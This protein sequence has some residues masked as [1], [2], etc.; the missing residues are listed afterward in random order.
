MC[1]HRCAAPDIT[2][3]CLHIIDGEKTEMERTGIL[4]FQFCFRNDRTFCIEFNGRKKTREIKPGPRA[5]THRPECLPG[6]TA[7]DLRFETELLG[8]YKQLG[9]LEDIAVAIRNINCR[10]CK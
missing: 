7:A 4:C 10:P 2:G 9:T 5:V 6:N 3:L 1:L 8:K